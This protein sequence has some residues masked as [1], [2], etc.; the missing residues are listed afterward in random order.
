MEENLEKYI[1]YLQKEKAYSVNTVSAYRNDIFGFYSFLNLVGEDSLA[2]D[3]N[4][5]RSWIVS[6]SEKGLTNRTINRKVSAVKGFYLFLNKI[7]ELDFNPFTVHRS[8]RVEKKLQIP[9][10]R[11]EINAVRSNIMQDES[12][13]S[14]QKL[15]IFELL[16]TLGLRRS[17]LC[18]IRVKDLDLA[19]GVLKVCGKGNKV[20]IVPMLPAIINLVKKYLDVF[21]INTIYSIDFESFLFKKKNG[22]KLTE[23]FV[24]RL[25]NVYFS[26]VTSKEKKSPHMLRHSFAT[27]LLEGGADV[28]S[29]KELMG[30][31]SLSSTEIYAQVN[32]KE[33]KKMYL[34][35]HPRNK[36]RK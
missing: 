34:K 25:I 20:R 30:H 4:L 36:T 18:N 32:L 9:F 1:G 14:L 33:L 8:L 24:Y 16:Y 17:E 10:S 6:L 19:N 21:S 28:N 29:V 26:D 3:Y 11:N 12:A 31:E 5:I 7:E 27:H 22:G 2:I 35:A 15:L 13:D 23:M